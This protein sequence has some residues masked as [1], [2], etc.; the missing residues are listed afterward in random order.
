M[1]RFPFVVQRY[2][3]VVGRIGHRR[4]SEPKERKLLYRGHP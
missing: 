4:H 1:L 3:G 2:I